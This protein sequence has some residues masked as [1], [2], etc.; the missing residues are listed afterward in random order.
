MFSRNL[1]IS[2][3]KNSNVEFRL[4]QRGALRMH[5]PRLRVINILRSSRINNV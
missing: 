2:F 1:K 4:S 5:D 3:F